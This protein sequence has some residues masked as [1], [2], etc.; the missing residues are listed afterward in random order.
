[1]ADEQGRHVE[2]DVMKAKQCLECA[3]HEHK[4]YRWKGSPFDDLKCHKGHRPR[5]YLP[6]ELENEA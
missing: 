5:F 6:S 2:A 1:M 4:W 3:H